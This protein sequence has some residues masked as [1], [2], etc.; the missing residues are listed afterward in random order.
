MKMCKRQEIFQG[1]IIKV[2]LDDVELAD[3]SRTTREVVYHREAV[4][5]AA[6]DEN[7]NILM[8]RQYRYPI[9]RDMLELPAGLVDEGEEPLQAARR[10][11]REETGYEAARWD[12]LTAIHPSPGSHNEKIHIYAASDLKQVSDQCLDEDEILTCSLIPADD[13]VKMIKEG[14]IMDGK[15]IIGIL[16]YLAQ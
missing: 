13:A 2:F 15:T 12:L 14:K 6:V 5:V 8:V 7:K 4:A 1:K 10:E 9:G 3:G 11:L 16:L